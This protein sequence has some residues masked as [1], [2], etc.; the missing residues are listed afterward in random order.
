LDRMILHGGLEDGNFILVWL[1]GL[2]LQFDGIEVAQDGIEGGV[3][4]AG[5][6][7]DGWCSHHGGS[8]NPVSGYQVVT[9]Q[10]RHRCIGRNLTTKIVFK[11]SIRSRYF[12]PFSYACI[13]KDIFRPNLT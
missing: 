10:W 9:T 11:G 2:H 8:G 6:T 1:H 7:D 5:G 3:D 13:L 12:L 4:D